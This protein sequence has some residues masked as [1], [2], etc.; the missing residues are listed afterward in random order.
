MKRMKISLMTALVLALVVLSFSSCKKDD[1]TDSTQKATT[2][3]NNSALAERTF[4]DLG[5]ITD[6][7]MN[8]GK[9]MMKSGITFKQSENTCM[10]ITLNLQVIPNVLTI[11]FGTSNC[12]C[13]DGQYRR[14]KIIVTYS[15]G[16][17]DSLTSLTTNLENYF[18]NDNQILGTRVVT[19]NGHNTSG[20]INWDETV[21]GSII[22]A[23]N[24]GTITYQSAFNFEMIEGESTPFVVDDNV[25]SITGSASGTTITGQAFSNV[26][27][28]PLVYKVACTYAVSG[29][30][31]ITPAG[32]PVRVLDY[33]NGECDNLATIVVNGYTINLI[34]P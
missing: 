28:S 23:N 3:D 26:I 13:E 15:Q 17:G 33:G 16:I 5:S 7:A 14:G 1:K 11:D 30:I 6:K 10:T 12:L 24:G 21:N 9:A 19:Y 22:L 18:V 31:E 4:K 8:N 27:T 20:H 2:V 25:F 29:V 34:L 32:E